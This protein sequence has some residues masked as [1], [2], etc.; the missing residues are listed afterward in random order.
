MSG[1]GVSDRGF[2]IAVVIL[3]FGIV[4]VLSGVPVFMA[5]I[6]DEVRRVDVTA[7]VV[8]DIVV[9]SLTETGFGQLEGDLDDPLLE[10][11]KIV[12]TE[13]MNERTA[14]AVVRKLLRLDALD[15][16][17]PIELYLSTQGGWFDAAFTI[18][19]A[20][21]AIDAPVD[22]IAI[23]GCYSSGSLIL[24]AGTG[25][26]AVHR[27]ALLSIHAEIPPG[28]GD[29]SAEKPAR[30]RVER[31]YH[32]RTKLP[33]AWFPLEYDRHYYLTPEQ[34]LEFGLVDEIRPAAAISAANAPGQ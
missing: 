12:V 4:V 1:V 32:E 34:A 6:V 29:W 3:L 2:R 7:E 30:E 16:A 11:R 25:R 20:M 17:A 23:G 19:D 10:S 13:T 14:K 24:A 28:A 27:N 31:I 26:R 22:T 33:S 9:D 18:I 5:R 8:S 21:E 15:P